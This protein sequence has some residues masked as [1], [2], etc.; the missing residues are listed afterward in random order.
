MLSGWAGMGRLTSAR[1]KGSYMRSEVAS[2]GRGPA[3]VGAILARLGPTFQTYRPAVASDLR[4]TSAEFGRLSTP[5]DILVSLG[6]RTLSLSLFIG[7][8]C[9]AGMRLAPRTRPLFVG[10]MGQHNLP[11]PLGCVGAPERDKNLELWLIAIAPATHASP[12]TGSLPHSIGR[13]RRE[14]GSSQRQEMQP[15]GITVVVCAQ[16]VDRAV[17]QRLVERSGP[18]KEFVLERKPCL[19]CHGRPY[20]ISESLAETL[21]G[22]QDRRGQAFVD[23]TF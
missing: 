18:Q 3:N 12:S 14:A 7:C 5:G 16:L 4:A 21:R 19:L 17:P 20:G 23:R 1:I 22:G 15:R 8:A 6:Q 9:A 13:H 10:P 2:L 11:M